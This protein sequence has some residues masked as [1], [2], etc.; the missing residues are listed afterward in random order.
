M[1]DLEKFEDED[2][3][4]LHTDSEQ[5]QCPECDKNRKR[6]IQIIDVDRYVNALSD[7]D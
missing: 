7:W 4:T 5:C 3:S 2:A 6:Y 1:V